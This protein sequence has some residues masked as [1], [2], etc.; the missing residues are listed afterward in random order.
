M[1]CGCSKCSACDGK[2]A[3]SKMTKASPKTKVKIRKKSY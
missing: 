1:S 3:S 2:K